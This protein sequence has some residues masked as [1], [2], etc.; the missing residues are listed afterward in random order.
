MAGKLFLS[1]LLLLLVAC[2]LATNAQSI[3][4]AAIEREEYAVYSA[5]LSGIYP[6]AGATSLVISNPA[7]AN[8]F[9]ADVTERNIQ[10]AMPGGPRVSQDTFTDL[11]HRDKSNR[12]LE[13]RLDVSTDYALV[14]FREIKRL[15]NDFAMSNDLSE[16]FKEKYPGAFGFISLSRVGFNARMDEA[17]VF[18][19]WK[20]GHSL[21]GEGEFVLLSKQG[22]VWTIVNRAQLY[23]S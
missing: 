7:G 5:M 8:R 23:I 22:R 16:E 9:L 13:R 4:N 14:D 10:F 6:K 21:C 19:T 11:L 18:V 3:E 12:W 17:A 1:V 2:P 20:C 15:F